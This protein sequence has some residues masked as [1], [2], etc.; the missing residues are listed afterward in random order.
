V[1][2]S[3]ARGRNEGGAGGCEGG[4]NDSPEG[5]GS[6]LLLGREGGCVVRQSLLVS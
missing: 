4:R 6:D 5:L 1:L 2:D 3:D